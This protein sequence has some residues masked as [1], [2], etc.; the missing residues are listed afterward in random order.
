MI[1]ASFDNLIFASRIV[2]LSQESRKIPNIR[3]RNMSDVKS[4]VYKVVEEVLDVKAED[5]RDELSFQKDLEADSLD[6]VDLIMELE[7]EFEAEIDDIS[8]EDAQTIQTVG[9]AISYI[10]Q[11]M[12]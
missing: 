6:L 12:K 5:I 1:L 9:E 7:K 8:D 2:S 3:R 11:H 4:R 10:E